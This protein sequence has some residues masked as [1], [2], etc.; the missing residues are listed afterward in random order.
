MPHKLHNYLRTHRK[1]SG[2]S[3]AEVALLLGTAYRARVS[4]HELL[5][6]HPEVAA[7]FAYEIIFRVPAREL[8]AGAY[9][10]VER[11]TVERAVALAERLASRD[12]SKVLSR[13]LATLRAITAR[14]TGRLERNP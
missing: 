7:V 14:L 12:P 10:R 2:L 3:Q 5:T 1:R 9:E 6:R 11:V 8:F 13:K 4:R